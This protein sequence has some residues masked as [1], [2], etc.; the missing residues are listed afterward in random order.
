MQPGKDIKEL[1]N[2]EGWSFKQKNG[3]YS[4]EAEGQELLINEHYDICF[5]GAGLS[6]TTQKAFISTIAK[7]SRAKNCIFI[8]LCK[9]PEKEKVIEFIQSGANGVLVVPIQPEALKRVIETAFK[10]KS[11]STIKKLTEAEQAQKLTQLLNT[12]TKRLDTLAKKLNEENLDPTITASSTKLLKQLLI[13]S[14]S[15]LNTDQEVIENL[16]NIVKTETEK[17]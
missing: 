3:L 11:S 1:I 14:C 13:T 15:D 4:V 2:L 7:D 17:Y 6:E 5:V 10:T 9:N 8:P 16:I 12:V